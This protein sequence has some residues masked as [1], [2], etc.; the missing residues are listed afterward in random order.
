MFRAISLSKKEL[1]S[2]LLSVLYFLLSFLD[3]EPPV[4]VLPSPEKLPFFTQQ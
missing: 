1:S 3:K 2:F 4:K